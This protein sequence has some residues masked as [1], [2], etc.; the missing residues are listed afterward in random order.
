MS[1]KEL[2]QAGLAALAKVV[3]AAAGQYIAN[4]H[5]T[6]EWSEKAQNA[7]QKPTLLKEKDSLLIVSHG[8]ASRPKKQ[9]SR[10]SKIMFQSQFRGLLASRAGFLRV[11][12]KLAPA[13]GFLIGAATAAVIVF[14]LASASLAPPLGTIDA[15]APAFGDL[16][17]HRLPR[18]SLTL[19]LG[20]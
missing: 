9:G 18:P 13:G 15:K 3:T 8:R 6:P 7:N 20:A 16:G 19:S 17:V 2:L 4:T 11:I 10:A 12:G 1:H 5:K 14:V